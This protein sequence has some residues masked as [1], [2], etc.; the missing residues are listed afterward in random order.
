MKHKEKLEQFLVSEFEDYSFFDRVE[1]EYEE[2]YNDYEFY[3]VKV[4]NWQGDYKTMRFKCIGDCVEVN[5]GDD[6]WEPC[7]DWDWTIKNLWIAY[8]L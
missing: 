2:T 1:V 5:M 3:E 8:H 4:F 7:C 6:N